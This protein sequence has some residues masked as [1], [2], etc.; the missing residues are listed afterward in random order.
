[1]LLL[2]LLL[3]LMLNRDKSVKHCTW[4]EVKTFHVLRAVIE[5][6]ESNIDKVGIRSH[7]ALNQGE[8]REIV[9]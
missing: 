8:L 1:M 9:I 2:L 3:L 6:S 5:P 4:T 7:S